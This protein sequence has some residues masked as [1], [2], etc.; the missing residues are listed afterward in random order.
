MCLAKKENN[1]GQKKTMH[2][3]YIIDGNSEHDATH[4]GK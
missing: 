3:T 4:E 1:T 2:G